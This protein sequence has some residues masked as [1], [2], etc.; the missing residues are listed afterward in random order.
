MTIPDL[1]FTNDETWKNQREILWAHIEVEI[2]KNLRKKELASV[3]NY[4]FTGNLDGGYPV[5]DNSLI[6]Y[7]PRQDFEGWDYVF[8]TLVKKVDRF[9]H[10]FYY[11]VY[12]YPDV[13]PEMNTRVLFFDYFHAETFSPSIRSRIPIGKEGVVVEINAN[14]YRLMGF[15][16][17]DLVALMEKGKETICENR[18]RYFFSLLSE[19]DLDGTDKNM[20]ERNMRLFRRI[21]VQ[22]V[23]KSDPDDAS[24]L[25][26]AKDL[27]HFLESHK[28]PQAL[29]DLWSEVKQEKEVE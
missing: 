17:S 24:K 16:L 12:G 8:S 5:S 22:C 6:L 9:E 2:K 10:N 14:K 13:M 28:A 21:L 26:F 29:L 15:F 19:F 20:E 25:S 1:G 23:K 7:F 27:A 4:F 18:V 3:K 11:S